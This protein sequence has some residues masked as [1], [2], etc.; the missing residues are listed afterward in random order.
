MEGGKEAVS[1]RGS[2]RI[3][4]NKPVMFG[5]GDVYGPSRCFCNRGSRP[6]QLQM[7]FLQGP[8]SPY[9][10]CS[11]PVQATP[12]ASAALLL[13]VAAASPRQHHNMAQADALLAR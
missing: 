11:P 9:E 8:F 10:A 12:K 6:A 3:R 13:R 5:P 4:K 1:E 7:L 2:E